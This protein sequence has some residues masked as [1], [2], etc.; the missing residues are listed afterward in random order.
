MF[1]FYI[2]SSYPNTLD[3]KIEILKF[4]CNIIEIKIKM[5]S[6]NIL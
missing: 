5:L 1:E 6:W 4:D 2:S 3:I